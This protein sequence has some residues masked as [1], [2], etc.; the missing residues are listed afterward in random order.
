MEDA[1]IAQSIK[2]ILSPILLGLLFV[3]PPIAEQSLSD[4]VT[5]GAL[6]LAPDLLGD[7][8]A[9]ASKSALEALHTI[10]DV[11]AYRVSREA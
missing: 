10:E 6:T 4:A 2:R 7:E 8:V 9:M 5:C 1:V 11:G 3:I